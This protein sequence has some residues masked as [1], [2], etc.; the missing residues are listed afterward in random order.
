MNPPSVLTSENEPSRSIE[1]IKTRCPERLGA[2]RKFSETLSDPLSPE[3]CQIQSMDD[4]SPIKWHLAHTTWFFE[5]FLLKRFEDYQPLHPDFE[6]LFN[7]Y[8]NSVGQQFPRPKRGLISRPD[9]QE[10]LDYRHRVDRELSERF[11][12][13]VMDP[14]TQ[15]ILETG[16]QH[17]QQHQ[18]LMLTDLKHALSCNP[19]DPVY[20]SATSAESDPPIDLAWLDFD[21]GITSIG[22]E[23]RGFC[24]DN[25]CP[26]HRVFLESYQIANRCVTNGEYLEFIEDGGYQKPEYWLSLGW[27]T[28][29][30]QNWTAPLYWSKRGE[31]WEHFTLSGRQEIR[32]DQPVTHLSYFE[33]DA[34]ARWAGCRLPTEAE[35]ETAAC[36]LL[37]RPYRSD[38]IG[39]WSD[40]L[41]NAG[42]TITPQIENVAC[43]DRGGGLLGNVWQWTSSHYSP[44]P[45]YAPPEGALGEYNGKFMCNVFVLRGGSCATPSGHIRASYRNFFAPESRWQ[46]SGI[47]LARS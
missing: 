2:V 30:S 7:S 40:V 1:T 9:F 28:V 35:W 43:G 29:Q 46:F 14:Q 6:Y 47:R 39:N 42:H 20:R 31:R 3:D 8:Y 45:G 26:R 10:T 19:A 38:A 36:H 27:S 33:A 13:I 32:E 15:S 44:Y 34:Y 17:E 11:E 4:A 24:Y 12:H 37:K 41:I 16:I 25:E 5:T 18:E 23:G 22:Y 21:A